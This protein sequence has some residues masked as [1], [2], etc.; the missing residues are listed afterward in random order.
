MEQANHTHYR[1][2]YIIESPVTAL[3]SDQLVLVAVRHLGRDSV[4]ELHIVRRVELRKFLRVGLVGPVNLQLFMQAVPQDQ[5]V[6]HA[7]PVRLHGVVRTVVHA[8]DVRIVEIGHPVL[9][10]GHA[11]GTGF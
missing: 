1:D 6:R 3:T 2:M 7:E 10:G 5:A 8:A 11:G 4:Q 9:T